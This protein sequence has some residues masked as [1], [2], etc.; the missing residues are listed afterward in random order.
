MRSIALGPCSLALQA[1]IFALG[2]ARGAGAFPTSRLV[3]ARGPGAE[4]C[5]DQDAV[6]KAVATRLGY[7]PFFPGSDKTIVA[8]ISRDS[9]HLKGEVELV[10]E[11]GV[12]LGLR[13]FSDEPGKCD[14]LVHA[15]ALSIS[16]AIDPKSAETYAQGPPDEPPAVDRA[17]EPEPARPPPPQPTR[18]GRLAPKQIVVAPLSRSAE[19]PTQWSAGLGLMALLGEAPKPT[20]ALSIRHKSPAWR[21]STSGAM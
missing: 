2:I 12:E 21:T 4:L 18:K 10:D 7:D 13:E 17:I 14:D 19:T 9:D 8:R 16:I 11:H 5:P 20:P 15:M 6:R 3:Y 1:A